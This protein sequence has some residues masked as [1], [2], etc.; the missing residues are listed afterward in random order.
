LSG[1]YYNNKA[2]FGID[3]FQGLD[4]GDA[5]FIRLMFH[6]RHVYEHNGG[7]VD[8]RYLD[9]SGDTSVRLKQAL[10][11][12]PDSVFRTTG[13]ILRMA[14]NLHERFHELFPPMQKPIASHKAHQD[15]LKE[16]RQ[17][18]Y[19]RAWP[20]PP[21][22]CLRCS[23]LGDAFLVNEN[24]AHWDAESILDA[25]Q[26]RLTRVAEK[27]RESELLELFSRLYM[28]R[29]Q[30]FHGCAA[31]G[32]SSKGKTMEYAVTLLQ[33]LLP[34]F[35]AATK[36]HGVSEAFLAERAQ[37]LSWRRNSGKARSRKSPRAQR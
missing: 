26:R 17:G 18:A 28:L 31:R 6:R 19:E 10:R 23:S 22:P 36:R 20:N 11:E 35:A 5:E 16:F 34:L 13:L 12:T 25:D 21:R 32:S 24:W 7:E 1:S 2:W 8:Q 33:K 3:L 14:R 37:G 30:L 4:A 27:D 15:R 29:T 9:D